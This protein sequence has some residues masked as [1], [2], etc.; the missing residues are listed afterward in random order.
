MI[1]ADENVHY[2]LIRELRILGVKVVALVD[3]KRGLKD[4]E[5][6]ELANKENLIILTADSDFLQL[7]KRI[8]T[9]LILIR[10]KVT[11]NNYKNIA[12]I[13]K[14][15]IKQSKGKTVIVYEKYVEIL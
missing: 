7:R 9:G 5:I 10:A 6:V 4:S 8:K 11:K 2:R 3:F 13:I 1:L 12:I 15:L 14:D